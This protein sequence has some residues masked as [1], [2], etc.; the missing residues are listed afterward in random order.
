MFRVFT[1]FCW[2]LIF[3]SAAIVIL[4]LVLLVLVTVAFVI[5]W[6]ASLVS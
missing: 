6:L 1:V 4:L 5:G 2:G 3:T